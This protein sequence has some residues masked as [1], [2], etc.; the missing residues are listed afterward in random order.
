MVTQTTPEI[1]VPKAPTQSQHGFWIIITGFSSY[2][3]RNASYLDFYGMNKYWW[4]HP[5]TLPQ[6][7]TKKTL[8][9][10]VDEHLAIQLVHK[11]ATQTWQHIHRLYNVYNRKE[12]RYK[13]QHLFQPRVEIRIII[14]SYLILCEVS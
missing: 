1:S 13:S 11:R 14:K 9:F 10:K 5:P 2:F 8:L 7:A 12:K 3:K 6:S 4:S